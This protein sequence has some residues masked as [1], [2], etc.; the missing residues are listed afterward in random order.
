MNKIAWAWFWSFLA[1]IVGKLAP[2]ITILAYYHYYGSLEVANIVVAYSYV[3]AAWTLVDLGLGL[4]GSREV[5]A[6]TEIG[7]ILKLEI[8]IAR[9]S[10][11]LP[12]G[13]VLSVVFLSVLKLSFSQSA[14]FVFYLLSRTLSLDWL[15]RGEERFQ[16]FSHITQLSLI[17]QLF[18]L[19]LVLAL[20][21]AGLQISPLPFLCSGL[22]IAWMTWLKSGDK[23]HRVTIHNI[24][25]AFSHIS[26]SYEL[27]LVNGLSVITQQMPLIFLSLTA[28]VSS[29]AGFA[30]LHR[31]V[32]SA[33]TLFVSFGAVFFPRLVRSAKLSVLKAFDEMKKFCGIVIVLATLIALILAQVATNDYVS[34]VFLTGVDQPLVLILVIYFVLR[35]ARIAPMRFMI[36]AD[37]NLQAIVATALAF[38][39]SFGWLFVLTKFN[40]LNQMSAAIAFTVSELF[41]LLVMLF[42]SWPMAVR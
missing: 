19:A 24:R 10:I 4:Y 33:T 18:G 42:Q 28:P 14:L 27:S 7:S 29:F 40:Y 37:L 30:L 31:L 35:S 3:L 34:R 20:G 9:L 36:A 41:T 2:A 22:I 32:L 1:D 13:I 5:A 12:I 21:N 23:S 11:F 17:G 39:I 16:E 38:L 6:N 26:K 15:L 8:T 25:S